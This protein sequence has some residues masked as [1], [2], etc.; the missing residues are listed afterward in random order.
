[1]NIK[2]NW[3]SLCV[4]VVVA[5]TGCKTPIDPDFS[6]SP[7]MPKAG[8]RV[9]FTNITEEGEYWNW[10]FGDGGKSTAKNP[11]YVFKKPGMYD[12]VLMADS[13]DNYVRTR[14]I[15]VYDTIPS[16][17]IDKESVKYYETVK[18]SA[19]VYNPYNYAITYKWSFSS[20]AISSDVVDGE[21]TLASV[22]VFF[23]QRNIEETVNLQIQLGDSIYNVSKTFLIQDV[24]ARSLLIA[25]QDGKILR[26]R[27][28]EK[29]FEAYTETSIQAGIHPF[30]MQ[31]LSNKLYIFDAGTHVSSVRAELDGKMGDGN[32]RKIDLTTE[33]GF[34]IIHNKNVGA[35]HG[36]YNGFV[37]GSTIYW[38]DFG[39]FVY[40]TPNN[41]TV[42]GNFEWNGSAQT[43]VPYY[44]INM[45]SLNAFYP[46]LTIDHMNGGIYYYDTYYYLAKG[47]SGNGLYKFSLSPLTQG[48][49]ILSGLS[50][51]AFT[52][53]HINQ[54][55]YFSVT[56]PADKIGFWVASLSGTKLALIDN[57]PMDSP[58]KFISGIVVDNVSSKVYWAYRAPEG[59][60]ESDILANP[61]HRTGIKSVRLAKSGLINVDKAVVYFAPDVSAYGL[62][63]DEVQ[64]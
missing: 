18:L 36:F 24:P 17:Y 22:S 64:K 55:I 59:T 62:A 25:E 56:A 37:D 3:I 27:I 43:T 50:I 4:F 48:G 31:A 12:V 1:M 39:Q 45:E 63:L 57:A 40:K 41:N 19:L 13:N 44:L 30:Y 34:E 49:K 46:E 26:K 14:Q 8:E 33:T 21:S 47:G 2:L 58:A 35:E 60:T 15:T 20:N 51:R 61:N 28:F 11:T 23:N 42:L 10:T 52:I 7:E 29:G 32:I 6:Y 38:T 16:I 5:L 54:N 9:T 53:D